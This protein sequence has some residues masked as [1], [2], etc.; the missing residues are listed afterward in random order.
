[1]AALPYMQ[2]YVA[3]YLADTAHLSTLEHGAYLLLMFNYWQRGESFKAKNEQTLNKR[4][5]SVARMS[6]DEWEIVRETLAEF[7]E[8]SETEWRHRRIERDLEAVNSKSEKAKAAGKASAAKRSS[9]C[10]TTVEQ[11]FNHTDTD[12]DTDSKVVNQP[13]VDKDTTVVKLNIDQKSEE[14]P[15]KSEKE[16]PISPSGDGL[17]CGIK[18]IS[19]DKKDF[20]RFWDAYPKKVGKE[21]AKRAWKRLKE[22]HEIL[23]QILEAL[24]WQRE[25][26]QWLKNNGQF[27]PNP[28]TY[29]NQGRWLD[30]RPA[31]A[32]ARPGISNLHRRNLEAL[33][34]CVSPEMRRRE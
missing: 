23:N 26:E 6:G 17:T 14:K 28:T 5:A 21:A 24:V 3:D 8:T 7:F 34:D 16:K 4:L 12:T 1:M 29:L 2:L 30:E 33:K 19:S 11:T 32:L 15:E 20:D 25:S 22:P 13:T 27:I 9:G 18:P 10:S 31:E